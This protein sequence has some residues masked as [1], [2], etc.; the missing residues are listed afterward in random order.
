MNIGK[1]KFI[2]FHPKSKK[3]SWMAGWLYTCTVY[4]NIEIGKEIDPKLITPLERI[5]DG[6]CTDETE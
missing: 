3:L 5:H 4:D 1:T 6:H 2:I